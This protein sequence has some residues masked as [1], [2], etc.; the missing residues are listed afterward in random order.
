MDTKMAMAGASASLVM[1]EWSWPVYG[2]RCRPRQGASG[3]YWWT[4]EGPEDGDRDYFQPVH[5]FHLIERC[6]LVAEF[7][8]APP[9]TR[10]TLAP[11]YADVWTDDAL[12]SPLGP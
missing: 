12:L 9:G 8:D 4:G 3:W 2:M 6:P 5:G 10:V 11:G 7:L 1:G